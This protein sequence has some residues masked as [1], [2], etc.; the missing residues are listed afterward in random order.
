MSFYL[1]GLNHKTAPL[2]VREKLAF[3]DEACRQTLP[4][5]IDGIFIREALILSTCN[6][7][8]LLIESALPDNKKIAGKLIDFLSRIHKIP[9]DEFAEH[10]Y[11][12]SEAAAVRHFFRVAS[13]LDSLI[14]GEAQILG[15]VRK[16]YSIAAEAGTARRNLHKLLHHTF[17]VAKRVRTETKIAGNSVSIAS[18]AVELGKRIF[19]SLENRTIL[20]VGAGEMAELAARHLVGSGAQK[21]LFVNRTRQTAEQLA[22]EFGG[23]AVEFTELENALAEADIVICSTAAQKFVITAEMA[24]KA[25][26]IRNQ[27]AI[28]IDISVPR[29]IEPEAAE[30]KGVHLFDLDHLELVTETN[31]R[32]RNRAAAHAELI[33]ETEVEEFWQ[34]LQA[35]DLGQTLG[36]LRAKMQET[37]RQEFEKQRIK[38]GDL[39]PEQ[40]RAVENLISSTVNKISHPILYG[41]RHSQKLSANDFAQIL[42]TLLDGKPSVQSPMSNVQSSEVETDPTFD[43]EH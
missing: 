20:L 13:S 8:E 3:T 21:I 40:Q 22:A 27:P 30:A 35:M 34:S 1:F 10:F 42:C 15:Q 7:V 6:R 18:A 4:Q 12:F 31:R 23:G 25:A 33:I 39:T 28:Y 32:E 11:Q 38:L 5:L 17:H 9:A 19:G 43:F 26:Q 2:D 36:E 16:A 29:N 37:A 24:R 14:V 41:L